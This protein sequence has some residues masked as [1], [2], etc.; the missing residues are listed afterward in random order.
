VGLNTKGALAVGAVAIGALLVSCAPSGPVASAPATTQAAAS[1]SPAAA[2]D[3]LKLEV[4]I[5]AIMVS[6]VDFAADGVWRPAGQEEPLT[7]NQWLYVKQDATNLIAAATLMTS[8]GT[9]MDDARWVKQADWREWSGQVQKLGLAA[10]EAANREDKA[11]LKEAGDQL[12]EVCR[13]CHQKYKP[14]LP[15]MGIT[16]FPI[17]PKRPDK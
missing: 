16:R 17:Y 11:K 1:A 2:S 5:N 10:S 4:P 13:S 3:A 8:A 7:K 12:I 9:G 14:G 15:E 6:M